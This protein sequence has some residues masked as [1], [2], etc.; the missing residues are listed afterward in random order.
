MSEN[1]EWVA[2]LSNENIRGYINSGVSLFNEGVT[3]AP[4][5]LS[6][7]STF[8]LGIFPMYAVDF[9]DYLDELGLRIEDMASFEIT[10]IAYDEAGEE[11]DFSMEY[12]KAAFVSGD[13][14]DGYSS[15]DILPKGNY[16]AFGRGIK[17]VFNL[18]DYTGFQSDGTTPTSKLLEDGVGFNLQIV[19]GEIDRIRY[20][21]ITKLVFHEK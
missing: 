19:N 15:S 9:R 16:K 17:T 1:R 3:N 14:L 13:L 12:E 8:D 10:A 2:D 4:G 6:F 7:N 5:E 18:E 11:I 21:A 20:L